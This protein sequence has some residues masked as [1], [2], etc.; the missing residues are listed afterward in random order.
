MNCCLDGRRYFPK[1]CTVV[2]PI[3]GY[4]TP[5]QQASSPFPSAVRP[6][7]PCCTVSPMSPVLVGGAA[8]AVIAAV[9]ALASEASSS[10]APT[11]TTIALGSIAVSVAGVLTWYFKNT[12]AATERRANEKD[13]QVTALQEARLLDER[14]HADEAYKA[15]ATVGEAVSL[16]NED[17]YALS[18]PARRRP[19]T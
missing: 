7:N 5:P 10:P 14:R 11:S 15:I 6:H 13:A 9:T 17:R 18:R 16:L 12:I 19:Q 4:P 3:F 2:A 1:A 8:T